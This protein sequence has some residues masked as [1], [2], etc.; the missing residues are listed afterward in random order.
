MADLLTRA[1]QRPPATAPGGRPL[2]LVAAMSASCA[3]GIG[4]AVVTV[5]VLLAWSTDPASAAGA[6]VAMHAAGHAWLL[7]SGVPL[8]VP[9]GRLGLVPLGAALLPTALLWRAGVAVAKT[10]RVADRAAAALATA[11]LAATYGVLA[12]L[13]AALAATPEVRTAPLRA[14]TGGAILAGA[15]GGTGVLGQSGVGA[16]LVG[17]LPSSAHRLVLPAAAGLLVLAGTGALLVGTS[18]GW[19]AARS[20]ELIRALAP[21]GSG[22]V[23]LFAIDLVLLPNAV[24][25]AACFAVGPGFAVGAGSAVTPFGVSVGALPALP[26]LTALPGGGG[27]PPPVALAALL[28]PLLAGAVIGAVV[29]RRSAGLQRRRAALTAAASGVGTG[30][31]LGLAGWLSGGPVGPGRLAVTGPSPWQ[32][33]LAAALELAPVAAAVAWWRCGPDRRDRWLSG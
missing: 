1:T 4:L 6:A 7:S 23:G 20:G 26:L 33:A 10:A 2:P 16:I 32:V 19:H 13:V 17:R 15:A 30:L 9:G 22:G 18:L 27:A 24:V 8:N 31:V 11:T 12:A 5:V 29:V 21:G 28:G 3:A 25:W 14:L